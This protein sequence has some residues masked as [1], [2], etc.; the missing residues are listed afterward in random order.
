MKKVHVL[1]KNGYKACEYKNIPKAYKN[2]REFNFGWSDM[3]KITCLKCQKSIG[4]PYWT[5]ESLMVYS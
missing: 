4:E 3:G 1:D 5:D 2:Y